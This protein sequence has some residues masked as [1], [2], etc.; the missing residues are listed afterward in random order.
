MDTEDRA[1]A[2]SRDIF[3]KDDNPD[4]RI[5]EVRTWLKSTGITTLEPVTL[6]E[7]QLDRTT[8]AQLEKRADEF[9]AARTID[10]IKKVKLMGMPR[11]AVLKPAHAIYRLQ[12]LV[13]AL[14][15]RVVMVQDSAVGGV[16][17]AMKG[18]VI[19]LNTNTIDVVW[20]VPFMGGDTLG[21]R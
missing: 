17:L 18:I 8:V 14:G 11:Q 2:K 1:I 20:D 19:G 4:A 13:F 7:E 10:A 3:P 15:D 12:G 16:I 21:G 5:R 6:F 9:N